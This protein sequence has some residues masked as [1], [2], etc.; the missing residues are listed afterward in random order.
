MSKSLLHSTDPE[1]Y[2]ILENENKRQ[3]EG[4]E[5]IASE[6][7]TSQSVLECL[8]SIFTNK[9]SE[10]LPGKRYYGGNEY[11]DQL[12]NLCI[13]RALKAFNLD[14]EKWSCN[15]QPYS[16]SVANL[17]VYFSILEPGDKIM[18]LEL[19]SGGHLTHGFFTEKKKVTASSKYYQS[20]PYKVNE[21]GYIDYVELERISDEVKPKLI[22]CGT[23]AYSRD[24]EYD[25]F[26]RIA[27]KN[28]SILMADISHISGFVATGEMNNP[29]EYCD[30]VT[31]TTHKTLRGPRSAIIFC[32]KEYET[33]I[34]NGVFPGLQGGPH[35]HQI[36]GVACQLKE[37]MTPEFKK[38]I[39]TVRD[40]ARIMCEEFSLK[41]YKIVTG[42]TD[43]HL[44]LLDLKN[45]G[46]NGS[47]AEKVLEFVNIYVNKNTVP[48]D[49]SA[50]NPSGI[51]IGTPA[52]TTIGVKPK[53]IS[54]IVFCIDNALEIAKE[55]T[56]KYKPETLVNFMEYVKDDNRLNDLKILVKNFIKN[57]KL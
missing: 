44:F 38:Y 35:Q 26:K 21:Y 46:I 37:V 15:V 28:N 45:K 23:S 47:K 6:N 53:D 40:N 13:S 20:F 2:E 56:D 27:D 19:A 1:L 34:N 29:F 49:K 22:I 25:T 30:I 5:L 16:G 55:I 7:Y 8:G 9:Y 42:G 10:G 36:A 4:I 18:G 52:I 33:I 3:E 24:I 43:N 50:F 32:K 57:F 12:E 17:A 11:I 39:Q 41:R 48:G 51:R 14:P 31:T 54:F